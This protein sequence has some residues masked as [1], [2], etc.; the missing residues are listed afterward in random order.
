MQ[1]NDVCNLFVDHIKRRLDANA[2]ASFAQ[3]LFAQLY[4]WFSI[5]FDV[6]IIRTKCSRIFCAN[7]RGSPV[8]VCY[9]AEFYKGVKMSG[10]VS[11]SLFASS[12][13]W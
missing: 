3:S 10:I 1:G 7:Y 12:F 6:W 5:D 2:L 11:C 9:T 13:L 8:Q 4:I